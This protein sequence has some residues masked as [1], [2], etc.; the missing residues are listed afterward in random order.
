MVERAIEG[1][2]G[3]NAQPSGVIDCTKWTTDLA[4]NLNT[5]SGGR[6]GG[7]ANDTRGA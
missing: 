1:E 2:E 7:G 5:E 3:G 4:C 6:G